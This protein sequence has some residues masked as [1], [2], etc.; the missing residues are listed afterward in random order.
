[1]KTLAIVQA[2]MASTR[3]PGKVMADISGVP[4]IRRLIDR[5]EAVPSID[6]LVVATTTE[7]EDDVLASW[8]GSSQVPCYRGSSHCN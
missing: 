8:L 2:R 4:M 3:L 7:P 5:L 6:D 1:M